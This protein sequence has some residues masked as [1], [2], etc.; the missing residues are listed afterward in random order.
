[1]KPTPCQQLDTLHLLAL[2]IYREARGES[3][4]RED[5]TDGGRHVGEEI[6]GEEDAKRSVDVEVVPLENRA[7][8]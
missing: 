6:F 3:K 8:R 5:E 4:Q 2:A 7:E 1:M